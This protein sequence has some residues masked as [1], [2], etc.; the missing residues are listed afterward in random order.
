MLCSSW[1]GLKAG[2]T[3]T[4]RLKSPSWLAAAAAAAAESKTSVVCPTVQA[5]RR[6]GSKRECSEPG[7]RRGP[8]L[9]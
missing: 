7:P 6:Q 1:E 2:E 9:P 4:A 8:S 5:H 3:G